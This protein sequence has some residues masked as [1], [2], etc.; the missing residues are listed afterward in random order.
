VVPIYTGEDRSVVANCRSVSLTS[1]VCKQV[2]HVFAV[3]LRQVWDRG[4]WANMVLD[5]DTHVKVK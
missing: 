4:E 5:W 1:V 3:Y 2:E